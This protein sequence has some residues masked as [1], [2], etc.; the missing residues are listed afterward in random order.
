MITIRTVIL[1]KAP[2]PGFAKT[3]LI[4]A[5]GATGA[6]NLA[7]RLIRHTV[8]QALSAGIGP[9][10][11]CVTP[12]DDHPIWR[13]LGLPV[14]ITRSTQG[15]GDLGDRMTRISRRV[16]ESG[17]ALLIIGT[18]CPQLDSARLHAAATALDSADACMV[19]VSD[20]GYALIGLRQF[21]ASLFHDIPWSTAR[22]ATVTR[23]RMMSQGWITREFPVLHDIDEPEDL[24][25]LPHTWRWNREMRD[26][27]LP[28]RGLPSPAWLL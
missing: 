19:P 16:M 8:A 28:G 12:D 5:L 24:L 11:L 20:G 23:R 15:T 6:A 17:E 4:K 7:G 25:K 27:M 3:R 21:H 26:M 13:S 1:A 14:G 22:V 9:V 18:D 10:E 2:L